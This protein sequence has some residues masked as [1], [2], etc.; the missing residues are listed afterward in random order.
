VGGTDAR[1]RR[2]RMDVCENISADADADAVVGVVGVRIS[3][4]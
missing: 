3:W 2:R 4:K 1:K